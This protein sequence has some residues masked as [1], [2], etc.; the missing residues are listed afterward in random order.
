MTEFDERAS[1]WDQ[2]P[3]RIERAVAVAR[4]IRARIPLSP[5]ARALEYGCGTGLLSFALQQGGPL[6]P[7]TLADNSDGMLSVL[8]E[9]ILAARLSHMHPLKLDLSSDPLPAQRFDLV[10]SLLTPFCGP[11]ST[12]WPPAAGWPWRTWTWKT[13]ASTTGPSTVT[14]AS[15]GRSCRPSFPAWAFSAFILTR[16]IP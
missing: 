16:P 4:A 2:N 13:A 1:T 9:K 6:G 3:V 10:F 5:A 15:P 14:S 12:C 8:S 7:I 11:F